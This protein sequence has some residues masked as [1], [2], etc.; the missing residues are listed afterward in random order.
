VALCKICGSV[1]ER[2]CEKFLRR[3]D[4]KRRKAVAIDSF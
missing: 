3:K 2:K 1:W 4:G